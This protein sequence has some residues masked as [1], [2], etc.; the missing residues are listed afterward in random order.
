M[1]NKKNTPRKKQ[2]A[3]EHSGFRRT[4]AYHLTRFVVRLLAGAHI[5]P[6]AITWFG[7]IVNLGAAALIITGHL[8]AAG[9]VVLF[10]G[11]FD[12]LDGAV[13][14]S[15]NRITKFGGILD[16]TLDRLSEAIVLLSIIY[17]YATSNSI[18]G[19]LLV[20]LALVSSLLVSYIRSRAEASG[21]K[22][23]VGIFTRPERVIILTIGLLLSG[24]IYALTI[25]LVIIVVFSSIT[26]I[27]RMVNV[28]Q[29]T[30]NDP[31]S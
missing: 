14:R 2:P 9:F 25:S 6:D 30:K 1:G 26:I 19:V 5:S 7:F 20:G 18:P 15:T 4:I 10:A 11:F 27:Q 28:W 3:A 13:A 24:L 17:V 12:M 8:F 23:E 22:C 21:L 29:Q 16:S 31:D